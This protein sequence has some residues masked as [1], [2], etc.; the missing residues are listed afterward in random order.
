MNNTDNLTANGVTPQIF[1]G[2]CFIV[3]FF[4]VPPQ[5]NGSDNESTWWICVLYFKLTRSI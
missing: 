3:F 1:F 4:G 2:K 5:G